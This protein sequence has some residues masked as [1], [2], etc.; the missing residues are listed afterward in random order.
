MNC[1]TFSNPK[2]PRIK[3]VRENGS[4]HAIDYSKKE[5]T[6]DKQV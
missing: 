3:A 4:G 1:P 2:D 5:V 6:D